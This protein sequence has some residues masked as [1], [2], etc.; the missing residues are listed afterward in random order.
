MCVAIAFCRI[1]SKS[2]VQRSLRKKTYSD[3]KRES[4]YPNPPKLSK[5]P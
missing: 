4:V 1:G 2:F 3:N 5:I